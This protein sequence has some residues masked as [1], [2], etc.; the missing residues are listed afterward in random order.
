MKHIDDDTTPLVFQDEYQELQKHVNP[1]DLEVENENENLDINNLPIFIDDDVILDVNI[2]DNLISDVNND[3][4]LIHNVNN[5]R[6][7]FYK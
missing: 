7:F 2:D 4:Y 3:D 6:S 1:P 5:D